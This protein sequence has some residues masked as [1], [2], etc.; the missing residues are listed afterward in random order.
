MKITGKIAGILVVFFII[1]SCGKFIR[2]EEIAFLK[3]YEGREYKLKKDAGREDIRLK[4][5]DTVKLIVKTGDDSIKVY[6]YSS[7]E[8]FLKTERLLIIYVFREDFTDER[9]DTGVF[10]KKLY[11]IV[12]PGQK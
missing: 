7:K 9:F 5:G 3:G 1:T 6:C 11:D 12:E 4:S 2:D 8:D 10:E